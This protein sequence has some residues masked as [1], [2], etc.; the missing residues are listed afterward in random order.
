MQHLENP[1]AW[2]MGTR[3]RAKKKIT[4]NNCWKCR[5]EPEEYVIFET[6][7]GRKELEDITSGQTKQRQGIYD[8]YQIKQRQ[9]IYELRVCVWYEGH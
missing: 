2:S 6:N 5:E 7:G 3:R 9:G 4:G 8:I 1:T